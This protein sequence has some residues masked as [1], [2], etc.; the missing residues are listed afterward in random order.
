MPRLTAEINLA[1]S[2]AAQLLRDSLTKL[3]R[4]AKVGKGLKQSLPPFSHDAPIAQT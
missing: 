1:W 4:I 2:S 3:S